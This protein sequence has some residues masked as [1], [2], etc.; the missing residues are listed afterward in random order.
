[1]LAIAD[2]PV[3]QSFLGCLARAQ[4]VTQSFD[5]WLLKSVLPDLQ[6]PSRWL[7]SD[8]MH[9]RQRTFCASRNFL[10]W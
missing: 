9:H 6:E 5:Y 7:Q 1:M 2:N 8:G 10:P 3:A 4:H